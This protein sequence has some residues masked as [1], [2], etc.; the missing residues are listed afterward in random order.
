M[1]GRDAEF[2][3]VTPGER[4]QVSA[5]TAFVLDPWPA[6]TQTVAIVEAETDLVVTG[7][8]YVLPLPGPGLIDAARNSENR[9]FRVCAAVFT[10]FVL[11]FVVMAAQVANFWN[12]LHILFFVTGAG[13]VCLG[14]A[15]TLVGMPVGRK[16]WERTAFEAGRKTYRS[17]AARPDGHAAVPA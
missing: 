6:D 10:A 16:V 12:P 2:A 1:K 11:L 4:M 8:A 5:G 14:A 9:L 17:G 3:A 7:P 15:A 13:F